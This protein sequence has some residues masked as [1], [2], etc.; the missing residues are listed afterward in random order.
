MAANNQAGIL[1]GAAGLA[2]I[3]PFRGGQAA[4]APIQHNDENLTPEEHQKCYDSHL[5][6]WKKKEPKDGEPTSITKD[7]KTY[8]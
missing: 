7:D 5:P 3:P 4:A 8:Y 2:Q 6:E 1:F